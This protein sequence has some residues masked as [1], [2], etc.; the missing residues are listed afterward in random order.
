MKQFDLS[1]RHSTWFPCTDATCLSNSEN[2]TYKVT[3]RGKVSLTP[4]FP[5]WRDPRT[6]SGGSYYAVAND[7]LL[8]DI[9]LP[10]KEGDKGV[11]ESLWV[12]E[13]EKETP[14]E[15]H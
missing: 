7:T 13:E 1:L 10:S 3:S 11:L 6:T 4:D 8:V 5:G 9:G 15:L 14:V 12:A 2:G